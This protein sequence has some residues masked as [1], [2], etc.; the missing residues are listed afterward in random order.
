MG[1]SRRNVLIGLGGIVAAGG[2]LVGTGAF[3]TVQAERTVSVQTAGD[4]SA[5]LALQP[6]SNTDTTDP[7][8]DYASVSGDTSTIEIAL[9]SSV[10]NASGLNKNARTVIRNIF[11]VTNNGTQDLNALKI[12]FTDWPD[13]DDS[14]DLNKTFEFTVDDVG[15]GNPEKYDHPAND[16]TEGVNLLQGNHDL[17]TGNAIWVGI[18]VDLINGGDTGTTDEVGLPDGDYSL[19]ITAE[20][21]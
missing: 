14:L 17:N 6:T 11:Q 21:A 8:G 15:G 9:D 16:A 4:A 3:T 7:N 1:V 13:P 18:I 12:R 2:A 5:F 19:E 20:T 10:S